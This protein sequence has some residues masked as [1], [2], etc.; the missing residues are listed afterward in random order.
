MDAEIARGYLEL[1]EITIESLQD[2][3]GFLEEEVEKAERR[4]RSRTRVEANKPAK[5]KVYPRRPSA[6]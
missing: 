5:P 1:L 3:Q 4:K 2:I 6:D